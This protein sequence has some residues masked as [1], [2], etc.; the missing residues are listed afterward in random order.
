[1]RLE[2][3]PFEAAYTREN[4]FSRRNTLNCLLL[5][6]HVTKKGKRGREKKKQTAWTV[7]SLLCTVKHVDRCSV[8]KQFTW[9]GNWRESELGP[10]LCGN[11]NHS[12][13]YRVTCMHTRV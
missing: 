6:C 13:Y 11:I 8:E 12:V 3:V 4:G 2:R 10:P 9:R 5:R 1:M 7:H